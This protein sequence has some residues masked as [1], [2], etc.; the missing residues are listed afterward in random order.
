MQRLPMSVRDYLR[1]RLPARE[2]VQ[3][4]LSFLGERLHDPEL[5]HLTRHS[6]AGGLSVG[7]FMAFMPIPFQMLLAA[8]A[9]ILLRVNLPIAAVSVWISNPLTMRQ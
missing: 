5:W 4:Q 6:T 7:L 1:R 3:R 2:S 9:A 8:P